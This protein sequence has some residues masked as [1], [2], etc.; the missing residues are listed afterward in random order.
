MRQILDRQKLWLPAAALTAVISVC[1]SALL[2]FYPHP[3]TFGRLFPVNNSWVKDGRF[4][5]PVC[6]GVQ[7]RLCPFD[8]FLPEGARGPCKVRMN[9]GGRLKTLVYA[10]PV[11]VH[12]DPIEKKPV[13]HLLPGSLIYSLATPGCNFTC[14]SCQ[15]WEISQI[16]PEQAAGTV[17]AP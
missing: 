13:Y 10:K 11:S 14:K 7:C 15:N 9:T 5:F 17:L 16:Y 1:A 4:G 12:I 2:A 8:C 3:G 6:N